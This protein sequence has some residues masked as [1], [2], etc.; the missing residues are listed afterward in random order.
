MNIK[1]WDVVIWRKENKVDYVPS[2]WRV[3]GKLNAYLWPKVSVTKMK[4]L[5]TECTPLNAT[6]Y[7]YTEYEAECKAT[8]PNINMAEALV[9]KLQYKSDLS[10][11]EEY[12]DIGDDFSNS[13]NNGDC[14]D[15]QDNNSSYDFGENLFLASQENVHA[16]Q[17]NV[18]KA[19]T[20]QNSCKSKKFKN[21]KTI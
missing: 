9:A 18:P 21:C 15:A 16:S 11:S 7:C 19:E 5:V 6:E 2:T 14:E 10:S 1:T 8:V 20:F 13:D 4:N 17:E 3:N 12:R